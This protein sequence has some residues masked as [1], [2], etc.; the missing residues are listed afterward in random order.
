MYRLNIHKSS[1]FDISNSCILLK[2]HFSSRSK[3]KNHQGK[4]LHNLRENISQ[5]MFHFN[6][7][8][9]SCGCL[10]YY[11]CQE[12]S[13]ISSKKLKKVWSAH[14]RD[15]QGSSHMAF[16]KIWVIEFCL[17]ILIEENRVFN[18]SYPFIDHIPFEIH[19]L[20]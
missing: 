13:S 19:S 8:L 4:S 3:E 7:L 14:I 1:N 9:A 18:F 17:P 12:K 5:L 2:T 11:C 15:V 16:V 6:Y 10:I 20:K